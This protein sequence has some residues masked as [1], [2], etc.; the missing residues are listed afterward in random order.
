MHAI[1]HPHPFKSSIFSIISPAHKII[2]APLY[3]YFY[4][5]F[6]MIFLALEGNMYNFSRR[7]FLLTAAT[8]LL[9]GRAA[10]AQPQEILITPNSPSVDLKTAYGLFSNP[11]PYG[12]PEKAIETDISGTKVFLYLPQINTPSNVVV[13]S[14]SEFTT[15][16]IYEK[17]LAHWASH[18]FAV[19]APLHNDSIIKEGL[20]AHQETLKQGA[21]W[22][23]K[24]V[25]ENST[26]LQ[27]RIEAC[28]SVL[29]AM[30]SIQ[31]SSTVRLRNDRP[32]IAG[33][34]LGAFIS[35]MLIGTRT[36][37][38]DGTILSMDDPRFY[39]GLLLSPYGRG[40]MGL[41][42]D[43]WTTVNRPLM[44]VTGNGD[45]DVLGQDPNVKLEPYALSPPGNKHLIWFARIWQTL[46]SGQQVRHGSDDEPVFQDLLATTTAFLVAY[47]QYKQDIL[48]QLAGT[49]YQ[50]ASAH[51]LLVKYR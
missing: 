22:N 31:A 20:E 38:P 36:H 10:F 48:K 7:G 23:L 51:R 1:V 5:S 46:Y 45:S 47:G 50:D 37:Q 16:Q 9:A 26:I 30:P 2:H 13:F 25:I 21:Q 34:G 32:I 24:S 14:H 8:T 27:A 44:V 17:L 28:K 18:G 6:S 41:T 12:P 15:P 29:E 40:I 3:I 4:L 19:F 33:H 35:E 43:S 39:A 11:G 42:D 49:Y